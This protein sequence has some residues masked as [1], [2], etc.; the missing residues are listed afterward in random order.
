M[1]WWWPRGA[2]P[3]RSWIFWWRDKP[4]SPEE[5]PPS[6]KTALLKNYRP[7]RDLFSDLD[8]ELGSLWCR[9]LLPSLLSR[10]LRRL[11]TYPSSSRLRS[12]R[13]RPSKRLLRSRRF[14]LSRR[15]WRFLRFR[16]LPGRRGV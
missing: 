13:F 10:L 2:E 7:Y 15:L 12:H 1:P 14:R 3:E 4:P 6:L 16:R 8:V 9:S 5:L 11:S